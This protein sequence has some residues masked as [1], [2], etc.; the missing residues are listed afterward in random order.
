[1]K[2]FAK[3][4]IS[5]LLLT[6]CATALAYVFWYRP[7]FGARIY[8]ALIFDSFKGKAKKRGSDGAVNLA[9]LKTQGLAIKHFLEEKKYNTDVCF[10][11]DMSMLSG[12]ARFFC[13]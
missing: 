9:K 5:I 1:M 2:W 6:A 13:V 12:S 7:H 3:L 11:I 10:M 8:P 4:S